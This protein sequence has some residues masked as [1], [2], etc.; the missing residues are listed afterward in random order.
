MTQ[1]DYTVGV[2]KE[3][4][5]GAAVAPEQFFESEAKMDLEITTV[6]AS[7]LR[8]GKG[9]NRT[10]RNSVVRRAVMGDIDVE[11][12]DAGF[13]LLLE[14]VLG[15]KTSAAGVDTFTIKTNDPMPSYTI[16]EVVPFLGGSG[17]AGQ[18]FAGCV[19]ESITIDVKEG[20]IVT[21]KVSW[22]G[23]QY[24]TKG[25]PAAAS[26]PAGDEL[27]TFV[28]G[29]ITLN[30]LAV[31]NVTEFSVT[32]KNNFD[33]GGF[34]L[35]AAGLRA[36]RPELGKREITG[37]LNAEL[38]NATVTDWYTSQNALPIVVNLT[39][40]RGGKLDI[41]LPAVRTKGELPKSNG[42]QVSVQTVSFEAFDNGVAA[43][44]VTIAYKSAASVADPVITSAT[45][46]TWYTDPVD[47]YVVTVITGAVTVSLET[48]PKGASTG[49]WSAIAIT[50]RAGV[51]GTYD[52]FIPVD[53]TVG[54]TYR[55]RIKATN[56]AGVSVYSTETVRTVA[57]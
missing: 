27:F 7:G 50:P 32:I 51:P 44:P 23:K 38:V 12:T 52:Y 16:E 15:T 25:S 36:R 37:S 18:T 49:T 11:I 19:A 10:N 47:S 54:S 56:S 14:A 30:S 45:Y 24:A 8:P 9:V 29:S 53:A 48:L 35:G 13:A 20:A 39:T 57:P 55:T 41:T 1:L 22:I 3:S 6:S 17:Q 31:A 33:G 34:N 5:Y 21:A 2:G 42:G 28:G 40:S 46:G 4:T 43:Q 26:Y